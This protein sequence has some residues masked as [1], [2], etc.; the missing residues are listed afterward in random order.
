[1]VST[2]QPLVSKNRNQLVVTG[3]AEAGRMQADV[4]RVRQVLF[5]LLSNACKFTEKG[6]ITLAIS[7]E[8]SKRGDRVVMRV[9]DSGIGMTAEQLGRLF[10]AFTQADASTTRRFGGTGL[11]LVICRRF[12]QMMGGDIVAESD[13]GHGTTFTVTLP[14]EVSDPKAKA[15]MDRATLVTGIYKALER[16]RTASGSHEAPEGTSESVLVIDDDANIRDMVVR[17]VTKEGYKVMAAASGPEGLEMARTFRPSVITL[18][19]MMPEMDGWSVLAELKA[20][21]ELADIPVIMLTVLDEKNL[22]YA[23]GASDY[24]TKPVDRERLVPILKKHLHAAGTGACVLVVDDEE[25]S[26]QMLRRH[27][28]K[29]GYEVVEAEDGEDALRKLAER[30]P[31][32]VL[33][34]LFMPKMDGFELVQRLRKDPELKSLP[35]VVVTSKE[36]GAEER[37]RLS[38][39]VETILE[40]A[41]MSREDLETELASLIRS[42]VE[43]T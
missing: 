3:H 4:T 28:E 37:M 24:V 6:T 22:G 39:S 42:G 27:V 32:L 7:R 19:V 9:K 8:R 14:A 40:R 10:Q 35:V 23:L 26:R 5:N 16:K 25:G 38:G 41:A 36:L 29:E 12:A 20:D 15:A 34:D 21:V 30:R 31:A 11:G 13:Y 2:V 18:D 43:K 33:L 1:V 17:L